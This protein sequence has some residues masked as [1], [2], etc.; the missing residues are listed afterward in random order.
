MPDDAKTTGTLRKHGNILQEL[1]K[2]LNDVRVWKIENS[3]VK[4]LDDFAN[5]AK[6]L[7]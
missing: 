5:L 3:N 6:K 7:R 4:D 1:D 2:L